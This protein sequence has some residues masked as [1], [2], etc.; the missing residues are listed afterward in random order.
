MAV[1][2]GEHRLHLAEVEELEFLRSLDGARDSLSV[3]HGGEVEEGP[4]NRGA[5]DAAF[6][7]DVVRVEAKSRGG[8]SGL[9]ATA[10]ARDRQVHD[11][12]VIGLEAEKVGGGAMG[13]DRA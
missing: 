11:P 13:E 6:D 4:G 8:H 2:A 1:G 7:R 10:R 5:G 9:G 12:P 3:Y